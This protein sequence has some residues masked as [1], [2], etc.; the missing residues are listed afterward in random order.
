MPAS[1]QRHYITQGD[2]SPLIEFQ[3]TRTSTNTPYDLTGV[4]VVTFS[5]TLRGQKTPKVNATAL[6]TGAPSAGIIQYQWLSLD[7]DTPGMYDGQIHAIDALGHSVSFPNGSYVEV[8]I[9]A[10]R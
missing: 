8:H 9:L 4:T 3:I 10:R 5:M 1:I 7:T 2:L 6:I